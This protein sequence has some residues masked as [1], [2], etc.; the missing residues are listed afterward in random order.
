MLNQKYINTSSFLSVTFVPA[1]TLDCSEGTLVGCSVVGSLGFVA[2]TLDF[3]G[4]ILGSGVGSLV[5]FG[6]IGSY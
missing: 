3:V 4:G 1:R 2:D 5:A 6:P